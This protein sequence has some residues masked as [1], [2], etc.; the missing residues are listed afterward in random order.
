M[1]TKMFHLLKSSV[2]DTLRLPL[3]KIISHQK[4]YCSEYEVWKI[5]YIDLICEAL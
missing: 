3:G 4:T 5:R 1:F 2:D